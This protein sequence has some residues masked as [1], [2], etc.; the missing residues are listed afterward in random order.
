MATTA[1]STVA[2]A[3]ASVATTLVRRRRRRA[4]LVVRD[5]AGGGIRLMAV[6]YLDSDVSERRHRPTKYLRISCGPDLVRENWS[7]PADTLAVR[8]HRVS[9]ARPSREVRRHRRVGCSSS[10]STRKRS[11]QPPIASAGSTA[12]ANGATASEKTAR[13]HAERDDG[14]QRRRTP[15]QSMDPLFDADRRGGQCAVLDRNLGEGG[16]GVCQGDVARM[17]S[18]AVVC[19]ELDQSAS[20]RVSCS[21]EG[22]DPPE[23]RDKGLRQL[24][25]QVM[26]L[27]EMRVFV[28]QDGREL[29]SREAGDEG[30]RDHDA[31]FGAGDTEGVRKVVVDH[32]GHRR[33][34]TVNRDDV[35]QAGEAV[36]FAPLVP[37]HRQRTDG[38]SACLLPRAASSRQAWLR[39]VQ[40]APGSPRGSGPEDGRT[41]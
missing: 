35:D 28:L 27:S 3:T 22:G 39:P 24:E 19:A 10:I 2:P 4:L 12:R 18:S 8:L 6:T 1:W 34:V 26:T 13:D 14:P 7:S 41:T 15:H 9:Q 32:P 16:Q 36:T 30:A 23:G 31:R 11:C 33:G 37:C 21:E 20:L 17:P 29:T 5:F 40:A 25:S 38:E